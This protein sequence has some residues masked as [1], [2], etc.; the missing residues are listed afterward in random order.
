MRKDILIVDDEE[1]IRELISGI[2]QDEGY[3]ARV[4]WDLKS[5]KSE[6][7]K[8]VPACI[9]LDVWLEN[10][11][12]DGIDI[13]KVLKNSY[14]YVPVIMISGHGTIDLAIKALKIGAFDFIEKPFD[15]NI[16]LLNINRAIEIS[17][18]KNNAN[19]SMAK[20]KYNYSFIGKSQITQNLKLLIDKVSNTESRILIKGSIGSGKKFTAYNI[21]QK[22]K[23]KKGPL[24]FANTKR[25]LSSN[26]EEE[27]FGIEN[28]E[29]IVTKI[30][31]IE[32][33]HNGTFYIDEVCNL[34]DELQSRFI[35]LL[36]EKTFL[37]VNGK[38]SID[39]DIRIIAGTTKDIK[40]E[41]VN[42]SFR[43]DL[44]YRLNVV[45][46]LL[47]SLNERMEDIPDFI[48]HF[49]K[50]CS[51]SLGLPNRQMEKES[52]G[53]L[54]SIKWSGNLR[55]L[56]NVI[57][58]LLILAPSKSDAKLDANILS[59]DKIEKTDNFSEL[60]QKKM[61]SLNLKK[62]R[63]YFER[64]YIKLQMSRFNNNVSKTAVFIGM[65][66]SALHRKLKIL[67]IKEKT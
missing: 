2:L 25:I 6:L 40:Q 3:D 4:A 18:L 47:P 54:Q 30:G 36:T 24:I 56:K 65:E 58:Q 41:I 10:N 9:L 62:A 55:Q 23:R 21:H 32:Q 42:N 15:T 11:N 34:S 45:T 22:S 12:S 59:Y 49:L 63:E 53:L 8:R 48:D 20:E 35:K 64:E 31:L 1:D 7:I 39:V 46:I 37:R 51:E 26:L 38:Y 50:I 33:A 19:H 52:Y 14:S 57:E 43:E 66:R 61:V 5:L 16:L 27:L 29:G 13:L 17:E 44:Y 67:K 28:R 60:V